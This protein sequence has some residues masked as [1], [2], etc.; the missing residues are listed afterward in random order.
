MS[1]ARH[2]ANLGPNVWTGLG[3]LPALIPAYQVDFATGM[4]G[5]IGGFAFRFP[6]I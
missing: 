4:M 3:N 6:M 5:G 1:S 2:I